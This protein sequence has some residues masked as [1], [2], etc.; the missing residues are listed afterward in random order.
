MA[1]GR[2]WF[3]V[4]LITCLLHL[5]PPSFLQAFLSPQLRKEKGKAT[6]MTLDEMI[7]AIQINSQTNGFISPSKATG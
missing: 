4:A 2:P 6:K 3:I 7:E 5:T 1:L